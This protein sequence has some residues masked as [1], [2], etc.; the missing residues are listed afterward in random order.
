LIALILLP[1]LTI[2]YPT[3]YTKIE[4]EP[5]KI[6]M[7]LR[8]ILKS[9]NFYIIV[10]QPEIPIGNRD[11]LLTIDV[12]GS[13]DDNCNCVD[14]DN[15]IGCTGDCK[16][17]DARNA[18]KTLLECADPSD[19]VSLMKF[20]W[21]SGA[22]EDFTCDYTWW[23]GWFPSWCRGH[24]IEQLTSY[25]FLDEG[26]KTTIS[27]EVDTLEADGGTPIQTTLEWGK[28]IIENQADPDRNRMMI[29]MSDGEEYCGGDPCGYMQGG[30]FIDGVPIYTIGF[31]ISQGS[32]AEQDLECIAEESGGEYFRAE[33]GEQLREIFCEIVK[34]PEAEVEEFF[35]YIEEEISKRLLDIEFNVSYT[36]LFSTEI[37]NEDP[38]LR[39]KYS[40][41]N[42]RDPKNMTLNYTLYEN[43][44]FL[45]SGREDFEIT[46]TYTKEFIEP[47]EQ[48]TNYTSLAYLNTSTVTLESNVTL[49]FD[50][51]K[52]KLE[53]Y[54]LLVKYNVTVDDR[55]LAEKVNVPTYILTKYY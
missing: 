25:L 19:R 41:D 6:R 46:D 51:N 5:Q 12:S 10:D 16:I 53:V 27:N 50:D 24:G 52:V 44:T 55:L 32:A 54:N 21:I 3:I 30:N 42:Y 20:T 4:E 22:P 38:N 28:D 7:Y 49:P 43:E 11:I 47:L 18:S 45:T 17:C 39:V 8:D 13:M 37:T 48:N 29:L 14:I 40:V 1:I 9:L 31:D 23:C 15:C 33:T 36:F 34:G 2:N 26:N 35:E